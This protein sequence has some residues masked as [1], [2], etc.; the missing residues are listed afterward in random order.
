[1]SSFFSIRTLY[2]RIEICYQKLKI[3]TPHGQQD[4]PRST[5]PLRQNICVVCIHDRFLYIIQTTTYRLTNISLRIKLITLTF[6]LNQKQGLG[7][8]SPAKRSKITGFRWSNP[9]RRINKL[10]FNLLKFDASQFTFNHIILDPEIM[11]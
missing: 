4:G 2:Y 9:I 11:K 10:W 5:L 8:N 6:N 1:M 7:D 3:K